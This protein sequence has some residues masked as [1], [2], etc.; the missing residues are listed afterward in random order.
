MFFS[1]SMKYPAF[2]VTVI[3]L[4]ALP[5]AGDGRDSPFLH[6]HQQE[7]APETD[8]CQDLRGNRRSSQLEPSTTPV[9][10]TLQYHVSRGVKSTAQVKH[11]ILYYNKSLHNSVKKKK[12]GQKSQKEFFSF[13][14]FF[15][16]IYI[17]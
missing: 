11:S 2:P 9:S 17:G 12:K 13:D 16:Y 3:I 6:W 5:V 15:I 7:A 4:L 8:D 1:V 10:S 14:F